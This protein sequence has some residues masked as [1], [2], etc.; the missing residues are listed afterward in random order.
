QQKVTPVRRTK[1]AVKPK[2]IPI[3]PKKARR[4]RI[5]IDTDTKKP[6]DKKT[7]KLKKRRW[8]YFQVVNLIPWLENNGID[9]GWMFQDLETLKQVQ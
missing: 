4:K 5:R 9:Y 3:R 7:K 2:L 8:K 6:D 1:Q